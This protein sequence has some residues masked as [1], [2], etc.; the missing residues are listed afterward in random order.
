[1][2]LKSLEADMKR[3]CDPFVNT[4]FL[5]QHNRRTIKL[6]ICICQVLSHSVSGSWGLYNNSRLLKKLTIRIP[7]LSFKTP[8]YS[9]YRYRR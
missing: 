1:M 8:K 3:N 2:F 5:T 4:P 7:S 6:A 9:L